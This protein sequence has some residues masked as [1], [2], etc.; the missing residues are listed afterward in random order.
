VPRTFQ[1][2]PDVKALGRRMK[3][4]RE[5][6]GISQRQLAF[7]GCTAAYI[8]R[9]EAGARNPSRQMIDAI[10]ERLQTTREWLETG[11][12]PQ[13]GSAAGD[14]IL[15]LSITDVD[16]EMGRWR[17]SGGEPVTWASL[18]ED[19]RRA[20]IDAMREAALTKAGAMAAPIGVNRTLKQER[21]AS[22][23]EEMRGRLRDA[24]REEEH[25]A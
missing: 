16:D 11:I 17:E 24:A 6:L 3:Q 22:L 4:R 23:E 15:V 1:H 19:E 9:L 2:T 10:A 18:D 7:P 13:D 14:V 20:V 5:G 8:S 12:G 21:L 25:V